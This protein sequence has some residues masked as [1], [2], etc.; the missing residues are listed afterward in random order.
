[1]G[2]IKANRGGSPWC[3]SFL[4]LLKLNNRNLLHLYLV[5]ITPSRTRRGVSKKGGCEGWE[6]GVG[7]PPPP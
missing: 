6:G 4:F 2:G 1:M 7:V 5:N 3:F